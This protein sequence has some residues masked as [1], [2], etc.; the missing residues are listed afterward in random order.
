[1]FCS[2]FYL[3]LKSFLLNNIIYKFQ[4]NYPIDLNQINLDQ[5]IN[6]KIAINNFDDLLSFYGLNRNSKD[7]LWNKFLL[8]IMFF[9]FLRYLFISQ[10]DPV[11]DYD[12]CLIAGDFTLLFKSF[13]KSFNFILILI[14][15]W[16]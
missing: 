15:F 4:I 9:G 16:N 7:K 11:K 5:E 14:F 10:L 13:R 2:N 1:M 3:K 8:L 12:Y 6:D